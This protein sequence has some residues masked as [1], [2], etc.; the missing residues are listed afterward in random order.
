MGGTDFNPFMTKAPCVKALIVCASPLLSTRKIQT[1]SIG[2]GYQIIAVDGGYDTIAKTGLRPVV[3][4]GDFDSTEY[5]LEEIRYNSETVIELPVEKDKTD[6]EEALEE[7]FYRG[8]NTIAVF[9][10]LGGKRID[11]ALNNLLVLSKYASSD[12]KI[13]VYSDDGK[14]VMLLLAE[15]AKLYVDDIKH[16]NMAKPFS[17]IPVVDSTVSIKN[18]QY[19]YEGG[20]NMSS[21]HAMSNIAEAGGVIEIKK[22]TVY[23]SYSLKD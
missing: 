14:Q 15:G 22:G 20:V 7:T 16:L 21:S 19:E 12:R 10:I 9:G 17:I 8:F 5:D 23:V 4:I 18:M 1:M 13:E 2:D 6:F 3:T 11:F